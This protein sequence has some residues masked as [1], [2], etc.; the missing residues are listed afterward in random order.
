MEF[1]AVAL[2]ALW[3]F[4]SGPCLTDLWA[5]APPPHPPTRVVVMKASK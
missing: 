2:I 1:R 5:K 4:L 3:T